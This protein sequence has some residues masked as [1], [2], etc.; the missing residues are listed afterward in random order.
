MLD[1]GAFALDGLWRPISVGAFVLDGRQRPISMG[2]FVL[3]GLR[4]PI[5]KL[6]F[7]RIVF[8]RIELQYSH[9]SPVPITAPG[10]IIFQGMSSGEMVR[11]E[12]SFQ[13]LG[14]GIPSAELHR[15]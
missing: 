7:L 11:L 4:R 1:M 13:D 2:A 8:F 12:E 15:F 5:S 9:N 14:L 3:G 6:S 10:K